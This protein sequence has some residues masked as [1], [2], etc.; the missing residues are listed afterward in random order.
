MKLLS[1]LKEM[2]TQH[3]LAGSPQ[4]YHFVTLQHNTI[5]TCAHLPE[6][7][8]YVLYNLTQ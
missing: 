2:Q 5:R 8:V 1:R 3:A 4:W 6:C 7:V